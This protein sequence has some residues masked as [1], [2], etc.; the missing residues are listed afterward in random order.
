MA[1]ASCPWGQSDGHLLSSGPQCPSALGIMGPESETVMMKPRRW[2]LSSVIMLLKPSACAG[3]W[4]EGG[5]AARNQ[6]CGLQDLAGLYPGAWERSPITLSR[7]ICGLI[8][9]GMGNAGWVP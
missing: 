1:Q 4:K 8:C 3:F 9:L 7:R 2:V 6:L 5:A